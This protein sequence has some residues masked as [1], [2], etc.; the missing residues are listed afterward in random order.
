[1]NKFY[2][3][4]IVLTQKVQNEQH[5][6]EQLKQ[7]LELIEQSEAYDNIWLYFSSIVKIQPFQIKQQ[8]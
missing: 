5:N 4:N 6:N 2:Q 3:E 8:I 7:Y 1:M